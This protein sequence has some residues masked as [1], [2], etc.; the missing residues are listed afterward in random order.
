MLRGIYFHA[1][2]RKLACS[3]RHWALCRL[4]FH[5]QADWGICFHDD[6]VAKVFT[7]MENAYPP[8]EMFMKVDTFLSSIAV[9]A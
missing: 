2:R 1:S 7:F 5:A 9:S 3:C 4:C 6:L 8:H